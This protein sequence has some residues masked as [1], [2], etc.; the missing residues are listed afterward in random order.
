[1]YV[2]GPMQIHGPQSIQP[3]HRSG[4]SA[5]SAENV[6]PTIDQLDISSEAQQLSQ[7]R[8]SAPFRTERVAAIRAQIEAGTYETPEKLEIAVSRLLDRL[9]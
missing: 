2:Y 6:S 5:G 8:D 1:M 7:A 4:A 9:M 3:P